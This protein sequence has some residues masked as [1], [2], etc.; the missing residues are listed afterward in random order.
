M[1]LQPGCTAAELKAG[2]T[3]LPWP[4]DEDLAQR[5]RPELP[6]R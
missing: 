5:R 2:Q 3:T 1:M 6:R 4:A